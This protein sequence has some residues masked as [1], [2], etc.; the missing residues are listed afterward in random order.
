M[1]YHNERPEFVECH[2]CGELR[3]CSIIVAD[4]PEVKTGYV[5]EYAICSECEV[6]RPRKFREK[7]GING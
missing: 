3:H 5:E 2:S 6:N 4:I 1:T 7:W